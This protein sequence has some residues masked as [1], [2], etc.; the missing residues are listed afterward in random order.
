MKYRSLFY[1]L[2]GGLFL[3]TSC[4]TTKTITGYQA[5]DNA[6]LW[7]VSGKDIEQPSYVFGTIHLIDRE[8]YF[9]PEGFDKSLDRTDE[10]VFEIDMNEMTDLSAQMGLISKAFM[11]NDLTLKDLLTKDEYNTVKEHFD[12]MGLPLFFFEKMKPMFLTVMTSMDLDLGEMQEKMTS[13]EME[14]LEMANER[15]KQVGGL[16]TMDFQL[17]LFDSIPYKEQARILYESIAVEKEDN[18]QMK[19]LVDMY[20]SQNIE[21]LQ[22]SL[23][24]DETVS[25]YEDILVNQRNRNWIPIMSEKMKSKPTFFAVG[26]GHLAG[27][28]GVL[29]LLRKAGYRIKPVTR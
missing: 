23:G 7:E 20:T 8:S 14:I 21:A 15:N 11:D 6:L 18:D 29:H 24:K 17:S 13:Y 2:L 22:Q 28:E 4:K 1:L 19:E 25:N 12:K 9:L 5:L 26:A 10:V 16:E 3:A 27:E